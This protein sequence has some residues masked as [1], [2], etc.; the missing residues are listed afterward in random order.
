MKNIFAIAADRFGK[1]L[2]SLNRLS[3]VRVELRYNG[4]NNFMSED[5][6][7]GFSEAYLH[8]EAHAKFA[9]ACAM[10]AYKN[11]QCRFVIFDALRPRSVQRKMRAFVAGGPYQEYVA[12]PELGS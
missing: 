12:D 3:P 11:P 1:D 5:L 9:K 10:L 8:R 2:L 6:Y 7:Q 4:K